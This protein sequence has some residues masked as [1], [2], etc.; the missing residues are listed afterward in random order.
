M[1]NILYLFSLIILLSS[2]HS[3]IEVDMLVHDAQIYTVNENFE[4]TEAMA[5]KDGK[6]LAIGSN[7]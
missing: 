6:I 4:I 1:K 2:C 5:I 3:P 7:E